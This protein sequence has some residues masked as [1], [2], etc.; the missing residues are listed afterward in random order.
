[1]QMIDRLYNIIFNSYKD[2]QRKARARRAVTLQV[3]MPVDDCQ[4]KW[5]N[6]RDTL[7]RFKQAEEQRKASGEPDSY[8][9]NWMHSRRMSFLTPFIQAKSWQGDT[10]LDL[11]DRGNKEMERG[12]KRRWQMDGM[13][14]IEDEMFF[15]LLP[16]F[17]KLPHGKK[18]A[19]KL[20]NTPT[21]T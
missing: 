1:M 20:K 7:V 19:V 2:S 15:S 21:F 6:P 9:K 13:E 12:K 4:K 14:D 8:K 16:Y 5:K 11:E 17:R 18:S 10:T 3:E